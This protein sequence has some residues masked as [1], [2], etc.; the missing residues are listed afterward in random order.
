MHRIIRI[1]PVLAM[2]ILIYVKLMPVVSGGPLFKSGF[3][4]KE[5]CVNGWYW[6]LLFI[7]NYATKTVVSSTLRLG[8]VSFLTI[9]SFSVLISRG[10]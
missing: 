1:L 2:A 8:L 7:Q 10:I 3:H 6:D 4:G 5:E 9:S